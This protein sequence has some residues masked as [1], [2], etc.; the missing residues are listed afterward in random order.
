VNEDNAP[1][2]GYVYPEEDDVFG[3]YLALLGTGL[4]IELLKTEQ[5]AAAVGGALGKP[6]MEAAYLGAS[7]VRQAALLVYSLIDNHPFSDGN[8]R[9]A[10]LALFD[11]LELNGWGINA[12]VEE[13]EEWGLR[14]AGDK[15]PKMTAEEFEILLA[16]RLEELLPPNDLSHSPQGD[17]TE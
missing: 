3:Y 8:K 12:R 4:T 15:P 16:P 14:M 17:E 13:Y 10:F 7:F 6:Q 5:R 9:V 1:Q 2:A 11:F